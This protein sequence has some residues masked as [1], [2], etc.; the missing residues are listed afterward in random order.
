MKVL[1]L[2]IIFNI[3]QVLFQ[4]DKW[5]SSKGLEQQMPYWQN[6]QQPVQLTFEQS[7][8]RDLCS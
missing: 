3:I 4:S 5:K 7:A 8:T 6:V 1:K 2:I